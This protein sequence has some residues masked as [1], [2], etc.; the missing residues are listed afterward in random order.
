M[1]RIEF[2]FNNFIQF[3]IFILA[4]STIKLLPTNKVMNND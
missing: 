4:V 2:V 3:H 1:D